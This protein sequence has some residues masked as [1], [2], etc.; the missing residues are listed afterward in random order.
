MLKSK[1]EAGFLLLFQDLN[2]YELSALPKTITNSGLIL[3]DNLILHA[4]HVNRDF[5]LGKLLGQVNSDPAG[6]E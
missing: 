6:C 4:R 3:S 5:S 2:S 1:C